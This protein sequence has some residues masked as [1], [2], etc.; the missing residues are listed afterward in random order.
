M[1]LHAIG[2]IPVWFLLVLLG[3]RMAVSRNTPRSGWMLGCAAFITAGLTA[4]AAVPYQLIGDVTGVP[5][6]ADLLGRMCVVSGVFCLAQIMRIEIGA[7]TDQPWRFLVCALVLSAQVGMFT[8]IDAPAGTARFIQTYGGQLSAGTYSAIEMTYVAAVLGTVGSVII[9][10]WRGGRNRGFAFGSV[11]AGAFGM[12]GI[13]ALAIALDVTHVLG[14]LNA[15]SSLNA[16]YVPLFYF[17]VLALV[18]GVAGTMTRE[19][20]GELRAWFRFRRDRS[21]LEGQLRALEV[22][23]EQ[24]GIYFTS[25]YGRRDWD[26]RSRRL[27]TEIEDRQRDLAAHK[28]NEGARVE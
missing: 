28:T 21:Q 20:V 19:T 5:N 7:R 23:S 14:L 12:I 18:V 8:Q 9:G 16:V 27:R 1:T 22:Q 26:R 2:S 15:V 25:R 11:V 10:S 3:V 4:N 13:A 17:S 24:A 6:I